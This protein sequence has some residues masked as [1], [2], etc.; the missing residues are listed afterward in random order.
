[1]GRE[2]HILANKKKTVEYYQPVLVKT[3]LQ[4]W[5]DIAMKI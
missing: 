3:K 5:W 4:I 2:I 1:M